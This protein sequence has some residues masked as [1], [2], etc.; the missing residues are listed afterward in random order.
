MHPI[1]FHRVTRHSLVY[2][3][4]TEQI[5]GKAEKNTSTQASE[6][7]SRELTELIPLKESRNVWKTAKYRWRF[8]GSSHP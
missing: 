8:Q 6:I 7:K 3:D 4:D 5:G 2:E 1:P